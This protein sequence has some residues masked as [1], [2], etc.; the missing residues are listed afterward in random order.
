MRFADDGAGADE[1]ASYMKF[2]VG[3]INVIVTD[4]ERS[5]RFY[6]DVLGFEVLGKEGDGYHLLSAD[7]QVLLL[8][9]AKEEGGR[10]PYCVAPSISFDVV[11]ENIAEAVR[12]LA[13]HD[14]DFESR[15][16]P[17]DDS[18]FI[19]D[20]DGLV[21]E[22][23]QADAAAAV[24]TDRGPDDI[25]EYYERRLPEYDRIYERPERQR[26][27]AAL[28]RLV[29]ERL[30]GQDVLEIACGTGYWTDV[31]AAV[32]SSV[33]ATDLSPA[34]TE[35]AELRV[36]GSDGVRFA[37]ADAYEM[38]Q[39]EGSFTAVLGA[40]WWSHVPRQD[41]PVFLER[42][43]ERLGSGGRVIFF[44][45]RYVEGESTPLSHEDEHGNTYQV[46]RLED[47]SEYLLVKNFPTEEELR[48]A[49]V[50]ATDDAVATLFRYYWCLSY[51]IR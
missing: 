2:S 22:V 35:V 41:L 19:R 26:D 17:G 38:H 39:L 24:D 47:G 45:N 7:T 9:V 40:F 14:V 12:H 42:L 6:R 4:L 49:V 33:V 36:K 21:L 30:A 28:R 11:V 51:E 34:L 15:W 20:P 23:I 46:R 50:G 44:D 32:A 27:L 37:V 43:H 10:P 16:K 18:V 5:L 29:R 3:E 48:G 25:V 13:G 1:E 31:A 8:G